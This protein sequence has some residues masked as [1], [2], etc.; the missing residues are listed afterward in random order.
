MLG[1]EIWR[2]VEESELDEER[3]RLEAVPPPPASWMALGPPVV[4]MEPDG[5]R[6]I[7]ES[8]VLG[9]VDEEREKEPVWWRVVALDVKKPARFKAVNDVEEKLVLG[10]RRVTGQARRCVRN[11]S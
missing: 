11:S 5:A 9:L 3:R 2:V 4:E 8:E 10:R 1:S 6:A 7:D